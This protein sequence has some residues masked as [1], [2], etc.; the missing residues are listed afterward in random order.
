MAAVKAGRLQQRH[1][2]RNHLTGSLWW[3]GGGWWLLLGV[4][5][6]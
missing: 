5:H 6:R 2:G 1:R 3:P 4:R